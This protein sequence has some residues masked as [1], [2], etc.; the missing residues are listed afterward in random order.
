MIQTFQ[1]WITPFEE[2]RTVYVHL[3]NDYESTDE[4]YPVMYMYDGHNLFEDRTATYGKSWG[5]EEFLNSYDKPL[6]M[7]GIECSRTDRLNEY[8]PYEISF[9]GKELKGKGKIFMDWFVRE[10]KPFIDAEYRT[11]P[12]RECTAIGGSSMGGLMAYDTVFRYNELFSKAACL[13]PS[14][15]ACQEELF[16]EFADRPIFEDTKLY[17]SF[18]TKELRG[19]GH[20]LLLPFTEDI[21]RRNAFFYEDIIEGGGHNEATWETRNPIYMNF[22]WK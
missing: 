5:L 20:T 12:F 15:M 19:D 16:R 22:L 2:T 10:F 7:V 11:I 4:R 9:W 17:F 8:C 18:G 6:I 14:I 13:S 3:P 21:K 1:T